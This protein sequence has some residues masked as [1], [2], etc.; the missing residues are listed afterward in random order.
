MQAKSAAEDLGK[1]IPSGGDATSALKNAVPA[2]PKVSPPP[3]SELTVLLGAYLA[4]RDDTK[5]RLTAMLCMPTI[6]L[7]KCISFC[8]MLQKSSVCANV[9]Y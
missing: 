7:P 5:Y 9:W 2:L 3:S 4:R 1:K 6:H 8:V